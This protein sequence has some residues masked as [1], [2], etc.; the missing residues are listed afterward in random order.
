MEDE[1]N[2][3]LGKYVQLAV[4]SVLSGEAEYPK[5]PLLKEYY[6]DIDL[7]E[8]ERDNKELRKMLLYEEQWRMND[9]QRG[10]KEVNIK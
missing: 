10:L 3:F 1:N 8:E 5:E 9:I 4:A 7:T 2:F 6:E